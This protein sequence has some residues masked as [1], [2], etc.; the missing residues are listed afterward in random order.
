ML[1]SADNPAVPFV[2]VFDRNFGYDSDTLAAARE[3]HWYARIPNGLM[4]LGHE[5]VND[6]LRDHRLVSDGK[7]YLEMHGVT[8]GPLYDWFVPMILHREGQDHARLRSVVR[9]TFTPRVIEGLRPYMRETVGRIADGIAETGECEFVETLANPFPVMVMGR[10]LGVPPQDHELFHGWSTDVGLVFS[11]A[12]G[13]DVRERVERAVSELGDYFDGL[14]ERRRAE[15]ADD[16]ISSMIAAQTEEEVISGEELRNLLVALVSAGH[17]TTRHQFGSAMLTL[18]RN[19]EQWTAFRDD[20]DRAVEEILRWCPAAPVLFR[21][22]Q[23]D[24]AYRDTTIP[25]GT[26]VMLCVHTANRD[27]KRFDRAEVFDTTASR[28]TPHLTLSAGPHFCLGAAAARAELSEA[29]TVLST[30]FGA[31][32][33]AGEVTWRNPVGIYGPETLPVRFV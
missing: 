21:F 23:E 1:M 7:R 13:G 24:I 5:E 6:L 25:A 10:L 17:D 8:S 26:F 18:C 28:Q 3:R 16:L 31:P 20:P 14:I 29:F 2:D 27:P 19:P 32:R 12:Y 15:P 4:V 9:R 22:A 11:L 33:I 30:R